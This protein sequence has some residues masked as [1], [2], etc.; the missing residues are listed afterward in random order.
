MQEEDVAVAVQL[1]QDVMNEHHQALPDAA[2]GLPLPLLLFFF[3]LEPRKAGIFRLYGPFTPL[4]NGRPQSSEEERRDVLDM[5]Y[6]ETMERINKQKLGFRQLAYKALSW[7][8]CAK[9]PLTTAELQVALAVAPGDS[10]LDDDNIERIERMVS[11]CAGLVTVDDESDIIRLVHY[12]T[13]EYFERTREQWFWTATANITTICV[14][15]LSFDDFASGM[16]NTK[17]EFKERL[18]THQLY[19]YA[20]CNWG[21]LAREVSGICQG[22]TEFLESEMKVEA[23]AQALGEEWNDDGWRRYGESPLQVSGLHMVAHFGIE[24]LTKALLGY[25]DPNMR[26]WRGQTPL[27]WAARNGQETIVK[28]LLDTDKVYIDTRD[29]NGRKPLSWASLKGHPAVVKLLLDTGRVEINP[30]DINRHTPLMLA[31]TKH[32]LAVIE[33]LL[34]TGKANIGF[35]EKIQR[36]VLSTLARHGHKGDVVLMLNGGKGRTQHT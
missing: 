32:Q 24:N 5:A 7:I 2:R 36:R 35:K 26:D 25:Q 29:H 10:K 18:Q 6:K 34:D 19:N 17:Y 4:L 22:V 3:I 13:Q 33:V 28:L 1:H 11:V 31:F 16:C 21:Y 15:Y 8:T 27:V 14:T 23:A 20:A 9:R 30:T 12:T